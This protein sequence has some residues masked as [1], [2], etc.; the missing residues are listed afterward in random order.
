MSISPLAWLLDTTNL[1]ARVTKA[2]LLGMALLAAVMAANASAAPMY[3]YTY[4]GMPYGMAAPYL[5]TGPWGPEDYVS[6]QILSP[7]RL[8]ASEADIATIPGVQLWMS[9]GA[10]TFFPGQ[11]PGPTYRLL[12][13]EI[14]D[15]P[16]LYHD[17][18]PF[19]PY[20]DPHPYESSGVSMVLR[21][22]DDQGL[23]TDWYLSAGYTSHHDIRSQEGV[24]VS[25]QSLVSVTG[26]RIV[27]D[28][29]YLWATFYGGAYEYAFSESDAW[30]WPV[31]WRLDVIEVPEPTPLALLA[32]AFAGLGGILW[33]RREGAAR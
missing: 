20:E 15:H 31:S 2:V 22:F 24:V 7:V 25:S 1:P 29:A 19:W 13:Q 33:R 27:Q 6:A 12:P 3:R 21:A 16:E 17:A 28:S 18:Y 14:L 9:D 4:N 11:H 30:L 5:H 8:T 26:E 32:V 23:P 10:H